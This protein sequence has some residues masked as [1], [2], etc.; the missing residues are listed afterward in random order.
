MK[1]FVSLFLVFGLL[2]SLIGCNLK[3]NKQYTKHTFSYFDTITT[4]VGYAADKEEFEKVYSEIDALLFKYN[5]LFDIYNTYDGMVN[6]AFLN[7]ASKEKD[8]TIS[9]DPDLTELLLFG[10]Y[11]Y[12]LTKG[13]TNI[14]MGGPLSVWH[15]YRENG[16]NDPENAVLP[17]IAEL[18]KSAEHTNINDIIIDEASS[19]ISFSD[20]ELTLDV[21]AIA[22]GFVTQKIYEYLKSK[23]IN[24]YILNLGGNVKTVGT[25]PNG[26]KF[27]VGI[28]NPDSDNTKSDYLEIL[29]LE[30]MALVT[31][32]NYQRFYT[33]N[34][35]NYHHI[36]DP[37]TL[38][39]PEYFTSVSVIC[40][41]A[42]LADALSTALFCMPLE[43]GREL[44]E[45]LDNTY[46]LW[47]DLNGNKSYSKGFEKF[48]N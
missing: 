1:K 27:S 12:N 47:V 32:G 46:A 7:S 2:L 4:V 13:K 33:V 39:P 30:N 31:S 6:L 44:I 11:A 26:K 15:N 35:K 16:L 3:T 37:E 28:E 19:L 36:I 21:G 9:I 41:D 14:A 20:P 10:K 18:K 45:S 43:K 40:E 29:Y 48:K 5:R 22:K 34:G 42:G 38:M 17:P 8:N 23:N 24:G 25:K